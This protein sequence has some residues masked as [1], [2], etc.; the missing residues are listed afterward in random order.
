MNSEVLFGIIPQEGPMIHS[1]AV[2]AAGISQGRSDTFRKFD[3]RVR[4]YPGI[5][6]LKIHVE[7]YIETLISCNNSVSYFYKLLHYCFVN[8]VI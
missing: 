3:L 8:V 6:T 5:H 4:I 1:G 2:I 7:L